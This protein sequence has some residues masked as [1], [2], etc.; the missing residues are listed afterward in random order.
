[1]WIWQYCGYTL[2]A[3][4][5]IQHTVIYSFFVRFEYNSVNLSSMN[6]FY[7]RRTHCRLITATNLSTK[8]NNSR[9]NLLTLLKYFWGGWRTPHH[10]PHLPAV[11]GPD[12]YTGLRRVAARVIPGRAK[13]NERHTSYRC[14]TD[15]W[16]PEVV[17]SVKI[18]SLDVRI[19][20][21]FKIQ[22]S[23]GVHLTMKKNI[24]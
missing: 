12:G 22:D 1:M 23:R 16:M 19:D 20:S 15:S 17:V 4:N 18:P 3:L 13:R 8:N 14:C 6:F 2:T 11:Y 9:Q 21:R 24:T 10:H 5:D 7:C